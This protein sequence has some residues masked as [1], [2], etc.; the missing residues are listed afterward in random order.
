MLRV[1]KGTGH[2]L[3]MTFLLFF[4]PKETR[5]VPLIVSLGLQEAYITLFCTFPLIYAVGDKCNETQCKT[6]WE[7]V[8]LFLN[9]L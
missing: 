4:C 5:H 1:K 7:G 8:V 6:L 2:Q 9:C 3:T